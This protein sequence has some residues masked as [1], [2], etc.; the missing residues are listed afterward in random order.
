MDSY[1]QSDS[2]KTNKK[3]RELS[4]RS[5]SAVELAAP[6]ARNPG[7]SLWHSAVKAE[8][9]LQTGSIRLVCPTAPLLSELP[10]WISL[11]SSPSFCPKAL[12]ML[13]Q[14]WYINQGQGPSPDTGRQVLTLRHAQG[15]EPQALGGSL[16]GTTLSLRCELCPRARGPCGAGWWWGWR[17]LQ[18]WDRTQCHTYPWAQ[19]GIHLP[20][21]GKAEIAH[22]SPL[23]EPRGCRV[24]LWHSPV[25]KS[26]SWPQ[27]SP[28]ISAQPSSAAAVSCNPKHS[29]LK[30][31][32]LCIFNYLDR[33]CESVW[34]HH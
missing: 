1:L 34:W 5:F 17:L 27:H 10:R 14:C 25:G 21:A 11:N 16:E 33:L 18:S 3:G 19:T 20:F 7:R 2:W 13:S 6:R 32:I 4:V 24:C 8:L 30:T 23:R 28:A 15:W 12:E 22:E 31:T 26:S 29:A 9:P